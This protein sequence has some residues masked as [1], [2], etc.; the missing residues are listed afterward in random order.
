MGCEWGG[1]CVVDSKIL[2][3]VIVKLNMIYYLI[4]LIIVYGYH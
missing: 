1:W 4:L 2:Y 3:Y